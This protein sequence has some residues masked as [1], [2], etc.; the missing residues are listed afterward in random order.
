[1]KSSTRLGMKSQISFTNL[2][3]DGKPVRRQG[4]YSTMNLDFEDVSKREQKKSAAQK[5]ELLERISMLKNRIR[6]IE[7]EE[8]K[9]ETRLRLK[10]R[11]AQIVSEA[12][13]NAESWN[14][15]LKQDRELLE[16]EHR[17]DLSRSA[18]KQKHA[19]GENTNP[20]NNLDLTPVK[21][22]ANVTPPPLKSRSPN[23]AQARTP[24]K[25]DK[26]KTASF[27][28][29]G[30][31]EGPKKPQVA[32]KAIGKDSTLEELQDEI[33]NLELQEMQKLGNME[34]ML[35]KLSLYEDKIADS[36]R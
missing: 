14:Q 5:K 21:R 20:S 25:V 27:A 33:A 10:L 3:D 31:L 18:M 11:Q 23:I 32:A 6:Y 19:F 22:K 1:M 2:P 35:K 29:L 7:N 12:K 28:N 17:K 9:A 4:A 24:L 26:T 13:R 16:A 15:Q 30:V 8:K 36:K 34:E